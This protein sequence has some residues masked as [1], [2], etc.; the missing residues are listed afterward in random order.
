[1]HTS[2]PLKEPGEICAIELIKAGLDKENR[3]DVACI[4]RS[5]V[6]MCQRGIKMPFTQFGFFNDFNINSALSQKKA[7]FYLHFFGPC[8]Y[9]K[10]QKLFNAHKSLP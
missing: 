8:D 1:M 2:L 3:G 6:M 10:C 5:E 9:Y 7:I 4:D